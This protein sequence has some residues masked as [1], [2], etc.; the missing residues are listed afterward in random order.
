MVSFTWETGFSLVQ[1]WFV[2]DLDSST[3]SIRRSYHQHYHHQHQLQQSSVLPVLRE[4]C[5]GSI[6]NSSR[7]S[8]GGGGISDVTASPSPSSSSLKESNSRVGADVFQQQDGGGRD[9]ATT[10][11]A[12]AK[13]SST[14]IHYTLRVHSNQ[15]TWTIQ[16][17]YEDFVDFD[18][19][20][21]R[22]VYHRHFSL[23]TELPVRTN[24]AFASP[25]SSSP[26]SPLPHSSTFGEN[27]LTDEVRFLLFSISQGLMGQR[28]VK[29]ILLLYSPELSL[30]AVGYLGFIAEFFKFF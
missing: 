19:Q 7:L 14:K 13:P 27:S 9:C 1:T 17:T 24:T 4:H 28:I 5:V 3:S 21:H 30:H 23:L 2:L 18:K 11:P 22:C 26:S 29:W 16:R 15:Q 10:T 6:Q 8:P 20:L 25:A 12:G